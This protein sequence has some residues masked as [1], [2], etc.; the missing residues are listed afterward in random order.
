MEPT[1]TM[2][3]DTFKEMEQKIDSLSDELEALKSAISNELGISSSELLDR[4][5]E[6]H[7]RVFRAQVMGGMPI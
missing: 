2:S 5:H 3:L 4:N 1:V 7:K 6:R